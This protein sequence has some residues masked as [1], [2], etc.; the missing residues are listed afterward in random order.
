MWSALAGCIVGAATAKDHRLRAQRP[1]SD[2][3]DKAWLRLIDSLKPF[4]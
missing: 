3:A 1:P 4:E 2:I